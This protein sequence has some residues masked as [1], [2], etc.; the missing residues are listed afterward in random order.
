M[1]HGPGGGFGFERRGLGG[2]GFDS[3]VTVDGQTRLSG[4]VTS[5]SG[6]GFTVAG[7]GVTTN[8][9]TNSSTQY[10]NGSSQVKQNDSVLVLGTDS[11]GTITASQIIINP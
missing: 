3:N 1:V 8:V 9:T 7:H 5:V 4:V 11:N 10:R 6:S 2:D